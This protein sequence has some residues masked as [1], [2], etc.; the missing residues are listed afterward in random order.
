MGKGNIALTSIAPSCTQRKRAQPA[1]QELNC[2][3]GQADVQKHRTS[4]GNSLVLHL[5][6]WSKTTLTAILHLPGL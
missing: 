5:A 6:W 2:I 4:L 3:C 1:G